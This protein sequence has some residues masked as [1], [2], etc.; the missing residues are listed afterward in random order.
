MAVEAGDSQAAA[1]LYRRAVQE[2]SQFL[3]EILPELVTAC[4]R[5]GLVDELEELKRLY[6]IRPS[7]TLV[8]ML[9]DRIR[10]REGDEAAITFL[11]EHVTGCAD[12]ASLERLLALCAP[13]PVN[14][15]RTQAVFQATQAVIG[16]LE[17]RRPD[18]Q[19]GH[20]GFVARRLHWQCPGCKR[21]QSIEP[22]QPEAIGHRAQAPPTN[23]AVRAA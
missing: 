16:H 12:L 3:P 7:P 15:A 13:K 21:W 11:V 5:S 18:Y 1:V 9:A 20:C 23:P 22:I 14:G 19:C 4:R 10:E 8:T 6:R 17:A 2:G